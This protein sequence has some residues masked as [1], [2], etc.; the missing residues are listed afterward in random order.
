MQRD[1]VVASTQHVDLVLELVQHVA[2]I[3][4]RRSGQGRV[5]IAT[6]VPPIGVLP[7]RGRLR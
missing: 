4:Q 7:S 3:E 5:A 2:V 6:N 1:A